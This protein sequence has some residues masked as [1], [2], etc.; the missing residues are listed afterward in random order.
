M[1]SKNSKI[2]SYS[3]NAWGYVD[4]EPHYHPDFPDRPLRYIGVGQTENEYVTEEIFEDVLDKLLKKEYHLE[5]KIT[6]VPKFVITDGLTLIRYNPQVGDLSSQ[7]KAVL[8]NMDVELKIKALT[9]FRLNKGA[10][11]KLGEAAITLK[12]TVI[13][14]TNVDYNVNFLAALLREMYLEDEIKRFGPVQK[15]IHAMKQNDLINLYS[16]ILTYE[17][18][19]KMGSSQLKGYSNMEDI[20]SIKKILLEEIARRFYC[21]VL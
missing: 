7:T 20:D 17:T 14:K 5:F 12:R 11:E 10:K 21:G 15:S 8:N 3:I 19:G 18:M 6:N 13:E 1:S 2:K 16:Q 4:S 9:E